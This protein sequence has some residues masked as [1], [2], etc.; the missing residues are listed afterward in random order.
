MK[1]RTLIGGAAA[2]SA[3]VAAGIYRFTDLF[4]KHYPP[5]PYD[6]LL[7]QLTDRGQAAKL[8]AKAD[9]LPDAQALASQARAALHGQTLAAAANADITAGRMTEVNGWVL[10]QTVAWLSALA[11]KA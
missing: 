1:R 10:P 6:D 7:G 2:A 5:T 8:G 11:A 9:N 3:A 4:V